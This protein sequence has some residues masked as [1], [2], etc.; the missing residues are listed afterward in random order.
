MNVAMPDFDMLVT[1]HRQDPEALE[2]FR[3]HLLREAVESAPLEHRPSLERLLER[4]ET[5]RS[6]AQSPTD[7]AVIAFRMMRDSMN[8]LHETWDRAM[9]EVA[10]LQTTLLIDR[11]RR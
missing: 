2:T 3:R 6:S 4:I 9:Y 7:A 5:A 8:L 11:M 1:L 10:G